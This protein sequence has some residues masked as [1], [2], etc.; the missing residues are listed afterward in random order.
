MRNALSTSAA[1]YRH[2]CLSAYRYFADALE[3]PP[4]KRLSA[5][6][7]VVVAADDPITSAFQRSAP[8]L[9][10]AGR[11][12]RPARNFRRRPLLRAYPTSRGGTGRARRSQAVR[13]LLS[14]AYPEQLK[15]NRDVVLVPGVSA[16]RGPAIRQAADPAGRGS[17]ATRRA[18]RPS[19]GTRYARSSPSTVRFWSAVS[20]CATRQRSVRF[21]DG[22]PAALMIEREAF[23]S[24]Q[25]VLRRRVLVGDVAGEPADVHAP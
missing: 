4:V 12:R 8:R 25:V 15:G 24:R 19:T 13:L 20:G 11:A 23:A 17:P 2:D 16:R 18:G 6:V 22:C 10:A 3:N 9:G 21:S 14:S 7:T 5:P 1:A